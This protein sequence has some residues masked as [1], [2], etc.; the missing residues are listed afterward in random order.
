MSSIFKRHPWTSAKPPPALSAGRPHPALR[1]TGVL[2]MGLGLAVAACGQSPGAASPTPTT[3][4]SNGWHLIAS[5]NPPGPSPDQPMHS[6]LN[7]VSAASPSDIWAVGVSMVDDQGPQDLIE[8][9]DGTTWRISPGVGIGGA[10]G[11]VAAVSSNDVWAVGG[12]SKTSIFDSLPTK[13]QI[14]HW[15]GTQWSIVASPD[16]GTKSNQLGSVTAIAANDVW[17]VG[18]FSGSDDIERP[19]IERWDG[20][21][22]RVVASPAPPGPGRSVLSAITRIPGT[23]QLWALGTSSMSRDPNVTEDRVLVERWDGA[24]WHLV[25]GLALPQGTQGCMVQGVVALSPTDAWAVGSYG[26]SGDQPPRPLIAHWDGTDWRLVS[27]PSSEGWLRGIAALGPKDVR[28][29][30]GAPTVSGGGGVRALIERWDGS[31][32]K[33]VTGPSPIASATGE[34][35][36]L[37]IAPDSAGTFWAVGTARE[38]TGPSGV[39]RTIVERSP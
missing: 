14:L 27:A 23:N 17:A 10:L 13:T 29:V 31:A 30:G 11:G 2:V 24:A 38:D 15:N 1:V 32:W 18:S 39:F 37:G 36:L 26:A 28:A 9:W 5:P 34:S 21:A 19:L 22:W 20:S 25:L 8:H 33:R 35:Y 7:A 4:P 12:I 16:P 6:M 3:A